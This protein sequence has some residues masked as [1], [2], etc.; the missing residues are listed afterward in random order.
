[1]SARSIF[2]K[3]EASPATAAGVDPALLRRGV[4]KVGA[5]GGPGRGGWRRRKGGKGGRGVLRWR[6]SS[7]EEVAMAAAGG[8]RER[9]IKK[10]KKEK[11]K[12]TQEGFEVGELLRFFHLNLSNFVVA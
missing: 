6:V 3:P 9:S 5:F 4:G 11:G 12:L 2:R 10:G 7:L 1:M 8:N